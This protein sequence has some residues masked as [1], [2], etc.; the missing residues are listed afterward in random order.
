VKLVPSVTEE[1]VSAIFKAEQYSTMKMAAAHSS[2]ALDTNLPNY[3]ESHPSDTGG[4]SSVGI[5]TRCVLDGAGNESRWR[6]D[7]PHPS[8]PAPGLT[9]PPIQ[10]K[11]GLSQG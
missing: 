3:K 8:R 2:K 7:F 1:N 6:R 11:S 9:Q 5:V 4:D 10:W